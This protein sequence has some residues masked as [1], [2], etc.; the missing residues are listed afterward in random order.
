MPVAGIAYVCTFSRGYARVPTFMEVTMKIRPLNHRLLV[1]RLE[2]ETRTD[3]GLFIP[4]NAKE[5]PTR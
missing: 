1:T 3:G 4:D 5:K 2:E